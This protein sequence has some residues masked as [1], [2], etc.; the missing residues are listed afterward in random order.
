MTHV[1]LARFKNEGTSNAR[2]TEE[3]C[4]TNPTSVMSNELKQ[5]GSKK[6]KKTQQI[7]F[8]LVC[9]GSNKTVKIV[10]A[11]GYYI[12]GKIAYFSGSL[13]SFSRDFP[14]PVC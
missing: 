4:I 10:R 5:R 11:L 3:N 13:F 9:N 8:S 14:G 7:N 2:K 1:S 6:K 12:G